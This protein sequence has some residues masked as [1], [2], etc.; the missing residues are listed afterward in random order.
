MKITDSAISRPVAL[1]VLSVVAAVLGAIAVLKMPVDLLPSIEY[2]RLTIE[3]TFPSA[4][5]YEV[6][7]LVTDPLEES[8]AGVRGLRG[9]TSRSYGDR[10]RITLEF[11]WGTRMD[12]TRL[13]VREKLDIASWGL[14]DDA[15]RPTLVEYDPSRRPFME[16]LLTREGDWTETS[17]F[18]RRVITTRIEQIDGVAACE[19]EGGADPGVY[20]RLRDGAVEELNLDPQ[21]ISMALT[22]ANLT[23]PGGLVRDGEKEFFLS[24]DGEF[25]DL[26]DVESTVIGFRGSSPVLLRDVAEVSLEEK[27][28]TEWASFNGDRCLILLVRKMA[29]SNTV[30]VAGDVGEILDQLRAEY[31]EIT[32]EVIQSDAEFITDSVG[33]VVEALIIGALLA[34]G[35]LFFFLRDWKSPLILGLSLPLSIALA[36]FLLHLCG[37]TINVM[38]LGG[39][40]LGTG[41][42]VD[43]AVVVLEAIYRRR[44][45]GLG[46]LEAARS[47]TGEVGKAITA[48]TLTT[49]IVFFPVVYLEGI[50]S[51]LFRDQALAVGFA[52]LASLLVA[53]TLI[54]SLAARVGRKKGFE[55]TT[56]RLKHSYSEWLRLL[57][58]RPGLVLL[59]AVCVLGVALVGATLLPMQ[60]LP[61]VPVDQLDL[62]F[63]APPGTSMQQLVGLSQTAV[64]LCLESGAGSVWARLGVR[65]EEG[66]DAVLTASYSGT[67]EAARAAP[68]LRDAWQSFYDFDLLVEERETLLGEILGGGSDLTVF[69]E[70]ELLE[71]DR[72]AAEALAAGA[73]AL[74]A[75]R[76]AD[77]DYL[78]GTPEIVLR[79]DQ[80]LL[81]LLGVSAGE[82]GDF[83]ESMARGM[84][85]T[86]YYRQ[87][88]RVDV[89]LLTGAGEGIAFE[90]L[91]NRCLPTSGG[92]VPVSRLVE[93]DRR[94]T[95]GFIE[96]YQGNRAVALSI[97]AT[98]SNL[99][100]LARGV[101]ALG[102]SLLAG[103]PVSLR[104]GPE[105]EEMERTTEGLLFAALLAV[106]LVYVL[107]AAQFESFREPFVIMFTVPMG[108]IGVVAA[109]WLAGQSWNALSG[110]GLVVLS[111]IV[112]NDGILLVE[113]ISQVRREGAA[114]VDAVLRAARDRFRPVIMTT[115][116]TVLGLLPMALGIGAGASLRQPLAIAIIGGISVATLLTLVLV[117][118]LYLLVAGGKGALRRAH[119]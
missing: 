97:E 5:P 15:G 106:G 33:G 7:R 17:D 74:P 26:S 104:M 76:E 98:G 20:V 110:I 55:D 113:R 25:R 118:M 14:P 80:Q 48:S 11:D 41:L 108:I 51:Q 8:L 9:Y 73:E 58:R 54:P 57:M 61:S 114:P 83:V 10:S 44:E 90:S 68:L 32:L 119:D 2:P 3:T 62:R 117:P 96:H 65:A 111:G 31:P 16:I 23:L 101:E 28:P 37:V 69:V 30:E 109:L 87:D 60:L 43:N 34:F 67:E 78:E 84:P 94:Q 107:L 102:E 91:L 116:T 46:R 59:V 112:V 38:S 6:E 40:A 66:V 100:G 115:V 24:L 19:L 93:W 39:L 64:D 77:P 53:V 81:E 12:F 105:M 49:I 47:G 50:A 79:V 103:V 82:I 71:V 70:G 35:V 56:G 1:T 4:S 22:G 92:L 89:L 13:E 45:E 36:L 86:T 21:I 85:A 63:S 27:P 72:L 88:E 95:P 18:A 52:L 99:A 29:E 75:V 42:L